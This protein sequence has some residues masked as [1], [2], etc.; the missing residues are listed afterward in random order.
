MVDGP[1]RLLDRLRTHPEVVRLVPELE[2][3]ILDGTV[4]PALAAD[5]LLAAYSG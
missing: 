1:G 5:R 4:T 2:R 3:Q